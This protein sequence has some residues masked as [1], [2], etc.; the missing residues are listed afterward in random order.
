[1]TLISRGTGELEYLEC[2]FGRRESA[3]IGFP[4]MAQ[5]DPSSSYS[6]RLAAFTTTPLSTRREVL[7]RHTDLLAPA[8]RP[9]MS[10]VTTM[11]RDEQKDLIREVLREQAS[12]AATSGSQHP[13]LVR[14]AFGWACSRKLLK[15]MREAKVKVLISYWASPKHFKTLTFASRIV[16][17]KSCI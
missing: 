2:C 6:T 11:T 16:S 4:C 7:P 15:T 8:T 13:R 17:K 12:A 1:M 14:C 3:E 5:Q 10:S 9:A